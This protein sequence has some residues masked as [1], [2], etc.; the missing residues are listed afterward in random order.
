LE[1][2]R[3]PVEIIPADLLDMLLSCCLLFAGE[4][5]EQ[6]VDCITR[7]LLNLIPVVTIIHVLC[8]CKKDMLLSVHDCTVQLSKQ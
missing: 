8:C 5:V 4:H 6:D 2:P 3:N 7:A 1:A